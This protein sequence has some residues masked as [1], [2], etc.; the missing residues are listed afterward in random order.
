MLNDPH[1]LDSLPGYVLGSLDEEEARSV[2]E[3]LAGC[4]MCRQELNAFQKVADQLPLSLPDALP[5]EDLKPRLMERIQNLNG[6]K[7]SRSTSWNA[8]KR[9]MPTGALAALA[10]ILLL[11]FSN[12]LL[13]QRLNNLEVLTGPLGMRAMV[14]QNTEAA[15]TASGFVIMGAD[16]LNGVLV[17]DKLK[18]LEDTRE[19]QVWLIRDSTYTGGPTFAVDETGY[20]GMRLEA[21]ESLLTYSSLMVTVEPTGGS[22]EPTGEQ[23]LNGSLHNP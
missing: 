9:L 16:G 14:L 10:L 13:W 20:R 7:P 5:S 2:A 1:I 18:Q 12:L 15:P 6:K 23:V 19:Y 3:H 21:P 22:P 4:Y 11:A 8:P 17:V